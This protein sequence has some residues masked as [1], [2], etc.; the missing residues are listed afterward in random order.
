M[1]LKGL[2]KIVSGLVATIVAMSSVAIP[3]GAVETTDAEVVFSLRYLDSLS[4]KGDLS[5][6]TKII[7][8]KEN[9]DREEIIKHKRESSEKV[10][11]N[12]KDA[13]NELSSVV[14]SLIKK[15]CETTQENEDHLDKS[16]NDLDK[17][18][19]WRIA[20]EI[21]NW[22]INNIKYDCESDEKDDDG[23][24]SFRKPQDALFVYNQ[25]MGLCLGKAN[26]IDLM[27]RMAGIP[28]VVVGTSDHAYNA[29]YL[30]S[31]DVN[32]NGWTLIDATWGAPVSDNGYVQ[33]T[34]RLLENEVFVYSGWIKDCFNRD[35]DY[36][37]AVE[38]LMFLDYKEI[39][40][41][42]VKK[43]NAKIEQEL[44]ELNKKFNND[45]KFTNIKY[46]IFK[47]EYEE[48]LKV[49]Y[50]TDMSYRKSQEIDR[51]LKEISK[52][53]EIENK[54]NN[55]CVWD[56]NENLLS[57]FDEWYLG[58]NENKVKSKEYIEKLNGVFSD[59]L[60]KYPRSEIEKNIEDINK[61]IGIEIEKLNTS[62][63]DIVTIGSVEFKVNHDSGEE[64]D[65]VGVPMAYLKSSLTFDDVVD[66]ENIEKSK[67][68]FP[69]FYNNEISFQDAN[70]NIIQNTNSAI[71]NISDGKIY[72][73]QD[74]T[75]NILDRFHDLI[76]NEISYFWHTKD[77]K[78]YIEAR[79]SSFDKYPE[80]VELPSDIVNLGVPIEIGFNIKSLILKGEE[81]VDISDTYALESIDITKSKRY[82]ERNGKIF[83]KILNTELQFPKHD[84]KIINSKK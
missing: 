80:N 9:T 49:E 77:G 72:G 71:M 28:C 59:I 19:D 67:K 14:Q 40:D 57:W 64:Y 26:L 2:R 29:V 42:A 38:K 70:K 74:E 24:R 6:F 48:C 33:R 41:E 31:N 3:V 52:N 32:R 62:F 10:K 37:R 22:V 45:F 43:L 30:S 17:P 39:N 47:G 81:R 21:Y 84:I 44:P 1:K 12:E 7:S 34:D 55:C 51:E 53:R 25:K 78:P 4:K 68:Y 69:V 76:I 56:D 23:K 5:R 20:R 8:F 60:S 66:S 61:H 79:G 82:E 46:V 18:K 16:G 75:N 50:K 13:Y 27:M 36:T 73:L 63:K 65:E 83:D 58:L 54:I 11:I 15:V 35:N